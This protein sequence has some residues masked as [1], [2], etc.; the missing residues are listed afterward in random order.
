MNSY[1]KTTSI[2]LNGGHIR[3]GGKSNRL[4]GSTTQELT[5]CSYNWSIIFNYHSHLS[6]KLMTHKISFRDTI[7]TGSLMIL[8]FFQWE[9]TLRSLYAAEFW[10]YRLLSGALYLHTRAKKLKY[11]IIFF[12]FLS[13]N[14][15]PNLSRL[16]SRLC[17]CATTGLMILINNNKTNQ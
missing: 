12:I 6:S 13:G 10:R 16:Q 2:L 1:S 14:R 15:T 4:T 5:F 17:A 11:Y 9:P 3:Y 8:F 7:A